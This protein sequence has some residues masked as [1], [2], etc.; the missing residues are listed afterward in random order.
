MCVCLPG[1]VLT[2]VGYYTL[3]SMQELAE[4]VDENGEC[5]VENFTIGRKGNVDLGAALCSDRSHRPKVSPL[6][7][8]CSS[9]DTALCSSPG[10]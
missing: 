9:Q 5:V 3:P 8:G 2:R 10:R 1:I 7:F 4:M 6:F